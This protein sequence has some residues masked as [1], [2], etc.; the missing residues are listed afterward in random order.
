MHLDD[1]RLRAYLDGE[2][3]EVSRQHLAACPDCQARLAVIE[4]RA[5]RVG[6]QVTRLGPASDDP[7]LAALSAL[8]R[9]KAFSAERA[10]RKDN[11]T[12]LKKLFSKPL[13]PAW[14]L[15][16]VVA[17]IAFSLSLAPVRAWAGQFLGLFRVQQIAILPVD[18][19]RLS[20]LNGDSTLGRQFG[21][22]MSNS[23]TVTKEPGEPQ[24]VADAAEAGRLTGF[25]VRLPEAAGSAPLLTVQ[26]GAAFYFLVNR[27]EAQALLDEAGHGDLQ[28]P[29]SLDGAK[30][31]IEIPAA[32]TAAYGDCP[33]PDATEA[34]RESMTWEQVRNCTLLAQAPS[35]TVAAPPDLD[36]Q[37]LAE[38]GLEFTGMSPEE[39][40]QFSQTVDW[41]STLV[42][43]I[44]RNGHEYGQVAVDGVMGN[45]IYRKSDD[46]VPARY[47]LLWVKNGIIYGLSGFG[48]PDA[49]LALANSMK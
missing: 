17:A 4:R 33:T 46:G 30:I 9:F 48:D 37:K 20:E 26:D 29:A 13:R 21:Q 24:V 6:D 42:V 27:A 12:M 2:L 49:G 16:T 39:A 18:T 22:I 5:G 45:L 15:A 8:A 38:I 14:G 44:P 3:N 40:R 7:S 10:L 19:S 11:D 34:E 31:E 36:I 41:T 47:T 28:L 1:G 35:P 43:P 23:M 25:T 32:V